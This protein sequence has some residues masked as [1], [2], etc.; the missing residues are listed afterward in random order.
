MHKVICG[1]KAKTV[2]PWFVDLFGQNV[3][4]AVC[5]PKWLLSQ[6]QLADANLHLPESPSYPEII[7]KNNSLHGLP[8]NEVFTLL[9]DAYRLYQDDEYRMTGDVDYDSIYN[10]A[11]TSLLGFQH[12]L[13]LAQEREGLLPSWWNKDKRVAYL[14]L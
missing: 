6:P 13:D 9:I 5:D 3:E 12:F 1:G 11:N 4:K 2:P 10:G 7:A 8:E 14:P